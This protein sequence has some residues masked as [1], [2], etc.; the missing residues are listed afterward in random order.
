MLLANPDFLGVRLST[1]L[2]LLA[3][4]AVFNF[5]PPLALFLIWSLFHSLNTS[6]GRAFLGVGTAALFL[7]LGW[8]VHNLY[9]G[10]RWQSLNNSYLFWLLPASL[11]GLLFARSTTAVRALALT[12]PVMLLPTAIFLAK[13]WSTHEVFVRNAQEGL[14]QA[15]SR[16]RP[17]E[18]PAVFLLIF[19]ELSLP[20]LLDESGQI[21]SQTY[22]HFAELARGSYWF[23]QAIA[24]A[25]FTNNS[26]PTLLTGNFP[27]KAG[28]TQQGYP[29]N[30]FALAEPYYELFVY[31]TWSQFCRSDRY[32]CL[33]DSDRLEASNAAL[34]L[35]VFYLLAARVVPRGVNV[36]LPDVRKN[37]G[38]FQNPRTAVDLALR[39][40]AKFLQTIASLPGPSGA[41]VFFHNSLPHSPYWIEPDGTIIEAEPASFDPKQRGDSPQLQAVL[42]RY[43][44]QVRFADAELGQFLEL[45]RRR[46]LYDASLIIVTSDHGVSYSPRAPGR[47]LVVED[48]Q[49]V[50]AEL[51]LRVPLF[52][53]QP[54]QQQGVVSDREVQLLDIMPTVADVLGLKVPWAHAGRSVFALD[55][56]PRHRVAFDRKLRRYEFPGDPS[57]GWKVL[58][59]AMTPGQEAGQS[60]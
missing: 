20:V 46:G 54:Q 14:Q 27:R 44:S 10:E 9:L 59:P 47:D 31:E 24:N 19:D 26:L 58:P 13:T 45:L 2:Q 15:I 36:Q 1:N 4:V 12:A 28:L 52:I 57:L 37:W 25:D 34:F 40:F 30:L 42:T 16:S 21:D 39:R 23:R 3:S 60:K 55:P 5:L 6:L 29:D 41:F 18:K 17:F 53:K 7:L 22:P 11:L 43:K 32:H 49:G 38:F 56:A 33:R 35:D 48:G 50:N 51:L 8:Q